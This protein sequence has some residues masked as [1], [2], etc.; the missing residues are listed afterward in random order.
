MRFEAGQVTPVQAEAQVF[1]V[2]QPLEY[3]QRSARVQGLLEGLLGCCAEIEFVLN[4]KSYGLL[5]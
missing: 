3:M 1:Q 4:H 5:V 2:S